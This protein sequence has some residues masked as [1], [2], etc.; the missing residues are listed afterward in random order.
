MERQGAWTAVYAP[1]G[2]D[3]QA[4]EGKGRRGRRGL[5]MRRDTRKG[6][7]EKG[8]DRGDSGRSPNARSGS[9]RQG[10]PPEVSGALRAEEEREARRQ[11]AARY[12]A[13]AHVEC[14]CRRHQPQEPGGHHRPVGDGDREDRFGAPGKAGWVGR[15]AQRAAQWQ[16][17]ERGRAGRTEQR[18]GGGAAR[19]AGG[20]AREWEPAKW[21]QRQRGAG[22]GWGTGRRQ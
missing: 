10:S 13:L 9:R 7:G 4:S 2:R 14:Q 6:K 21:T 17:A 20:R 1:E 12:E 8:A 5:G 16:D 18:S 3:G 22:Q 19:P 11:H 15:R